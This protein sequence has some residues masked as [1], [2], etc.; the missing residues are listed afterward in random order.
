MNT[1]LIFSNICKYISLNEEEKAHFLGF[2]EEAHLAKNEFILRQGDLCNHINFVNAGILRA[3][4]C[5][6]DGKES[7]VMFAVKD[8]WITDMYTFLNGLPAMVNIQAV[9]NCSVLTLSKENLDKLYEDIPAFNKF[10][11]ILMQNAYCR[12]QLRTIENLSLPAKD[13]Y[14]QFTKKYPQIAHKVTLKQTASYLG[15]TPEFLSSIR[16]NKN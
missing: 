7:T 3:Y 12:E 11:R 1:E 14:D 9:E 2:L 13:R 8:W 15:I 6:P 4:Y 16:G 10:F 5:N